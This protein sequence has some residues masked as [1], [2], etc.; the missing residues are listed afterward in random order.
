MAVV[1]GR[2]VAV[3][4][5]Q[6]TQFEA[7][8]SAAGQQLGR[9]TSVTGQAHRGTNLL[10]SGLQEL[11]FQGL[12]GMPPALARVSAGMLSLFGPGMIMTVA[13]AALGALALA[14]DHAAKKAQEL[15]DENMK[16]R[17]FQMQHNKMLAGIGPGFTMTP[18][19]Q[20][21]NLEVLRGRTV[22]MMDSLRGAGTNSVLQ[23]LGF[24][25]DS[26]S[27]AIMATAKV[28]IDALSEALRG[29][30]RAI[31]DL[32]TKQ[33][34][35]DLA[36]LNQYGSTF[37]TGDTRFKPGGWMPGDANPPQRMWQGPT[38]LESQRY[39]GGGPPTPARA[40]GFQMTP[41]AAQMLLMSFMAMQQGGT[42]GTMMALGG[43]A[44]GASSLK[45]VGAAA[46]PL[47]WIGFGISALATLF[48]NKADEAAR[49]RERHH[50]ELMGALHEGPMRVSNYFEGDPEASLYQNRRQERLG[51]EPRNGG[52]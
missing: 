42:Q 17:D 32:S 33:F 47:G 25:A 41:Q 35:A 37:P 22:E 3:L 13:I 15:E 26:A 28:R 18:R 36:V 5:A 45:G 8:M 29:F 44:S 50:A 7:R 11:A 20:L 16:V 19:E 34:I 48:G 38:P 2:M 14:F 24:G 27:A 39:A 21:Q 10:R 23:S 1:V 12:G 9:W 46:G 43:L 49:Q 40:G 30:N 52:L 51:G 6:T 31:H 4:E